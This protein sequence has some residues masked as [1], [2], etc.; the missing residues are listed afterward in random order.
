MLAAPVLPLPVCDGCALVSSVGSIASE[1]VLVRLAEGV[2]AGFAIIDERE[3]N[4]DE[5]L[6]IEE[7][8]P[9][10][11][12]A[13]ICSGEEGLIVELGDGT[14]V[15]EVGVVGFVLD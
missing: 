1:A 10:E 14:A 7:D 6:V 4:C 15:A 8:T 3:L 13:E 11:G 12:K 9:G 5:I 2:T